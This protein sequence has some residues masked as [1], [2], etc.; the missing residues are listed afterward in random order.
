[1]ALRFID[2]GLQKEQAVA[3]LEMKMIALDETKPEQKLKMMRRRDR[4]T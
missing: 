1:M 2:F 3:A 4:H